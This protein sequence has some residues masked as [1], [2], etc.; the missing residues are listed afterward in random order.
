MANLETVLSAQYP[1]LID[2]GPKRSAR[3]QRLSETLLQQALSQAPTG[4]WSTL[5]GLAEVLSAKYRQHREDEAAAAAANQRSDALQNAVSAY[6]EGI[7]DQPVPVPGPSEAPHPGLAATEPLNPYHAPGTMD[8]L[9]AGAEANPAAMQHPQFWPLVG[10]IAGRE[11]PPIAAPTPPPITAPAVAPTT[12]GE[13]A[14]MTDIAAMPAERLRALVKLGP[15][16]LK[17]QFSEPQIRALA[18][19]WDELGL[20]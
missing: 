5:G 4:P 16:A 3:S 18:A 20:E 15:D 11:S 14:V 17:A 6:R 10:A 2:I 1:Q 19:R 13:V 12:P 9:F 7:G 8:A